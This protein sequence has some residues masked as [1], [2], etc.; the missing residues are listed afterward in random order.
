MAENFKW[1]VLRAAKSSLKTAKSFE[2]EMARRRMH[3]DADLPVMEY[4]VPKFVEMAGVGDAQ[5]PV[6]KPLCLNYLFVRSTPDKIRNLQKNCPEFSMVKGTGDD[7]A[8]VTDKEMRMFMVMVHAYKEKVPLCNP[9]SVN[10][11]MGDRVRVYSG[12]FQ[13]VEGILVSRQGLDGGMVIMRVSNCLLVPTITIESRFLQVLSF[14]PENGHV[15]DKL[16]LYGKKIRNAMRSSLTE[17]GLTVKERI[18]VEDFV[19]RFGCTEIPKAKIR[20]RYDALLMMAHAMLGNDEQTTAYVYKCDDALK[21]LPDD[22]SKIAVMLA[23]F[24]CTG[25]NKYAT[26]VRSFVSQWGNGTLKGKKK[27]LAGDLAYYEEHCAHIRQLS[28]FVPSEMSFQASRNVSTK[29]LEGCGGFVSFASG[30]INSIRKEGKIAA[31]ERYMSVMNSFAS[32]LD[33]GDVSFQN[34][35]SDTVA[36]YQDWLKRKG[37][38]ENTV[39]F[40]LRNLSSLYSRAKERGLHVAESPFKKVKTSHVANS[41]SKAHN[42]LTMDDMS[43]LREMD[44]TAYSPSMSVARDLVLFSVY[45]HGM[46]PIDMLFLKRTD[47]SDGMLTYTAHSTGKRKMIRW[48]S[49]L[50]DIASRYDNS[51]PY[52]FPYITSTD[53]AIASNQYSAAL[54]AI[55]LCVKNIGRMLGLP[56]TLTMTVAHHSWETIMQSIMEKMRN[57][58]NGGMGK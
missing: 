33:G 9:A 27:E 12:A 21:H 3:E 52:I 45:A 37:L 23:L 14:A 25:Y 30:Y 57:E 17:G 58:V 2:E 20:A 43:R 4:Y 42:V 34:F 41:S 7:Y 11:K 24:V 51:S 36:A 29:P 54:H 10:L 8:F 44:L 26:L 28:D 35:T 15:Y 46:F 56:F 1:Y 13:G 47:I 48:D 18:C 53:K 6:D 22:S 50:R 16:D 55:N 39:A 40:Y 19:R 49:R 31:A 5:K 38:A 32:Y